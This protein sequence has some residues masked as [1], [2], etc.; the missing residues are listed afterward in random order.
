METS[1]TQTHKTNQQETIS[2]LFSCGLISGFLILLIF[3]III[4]KTYRFLS[5][6]TVVDR[7]IKAKKKGLL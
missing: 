7:M 2:K 3:F 1:T 4:R 5:G 6:R